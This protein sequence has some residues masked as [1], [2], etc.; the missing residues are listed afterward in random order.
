MKMSS[1]V[2]EKTVTGC[3]RSSVIDFRKTAGC[4]MIE[5]QTDQEGARLIMLKKI[6]EKEVEMSLHATVNTTKG[7]VLCRDLLNS[8]EEEIATELAPQRLIASERLTVRREG[9][10]LPS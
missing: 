8:T 7:V 3:A 10:T 1:F 2:I 4:L 9:Q 5:T 6:S